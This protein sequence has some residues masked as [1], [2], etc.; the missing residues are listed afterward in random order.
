MGANVPGHRRS[1]AEVS[2]DAARPAAQLL[3]YCWNSNPSAARALVIAGGRARDP[4]KPRMRRRSS[5][6]E[7]YFAGGSRRRES[8]WLSGRSTSTLRASPARGGVSGAA[9]GSLSSVSVRR[10]RSLLD[11]PGKR[12]CHLVSAL[13]HARWTLPHSAWRSSTRS[14]HQQV[15]RR[16]GARDARQPR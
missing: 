4:V 16:R 14:A 12:R 10:S 5:P 15:A 9:R 1:L 8:L 13:A 7:R 11:R 6:A 2:V 3:H